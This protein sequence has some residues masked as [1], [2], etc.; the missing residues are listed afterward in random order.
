MT[1]LLLPILLLL[2]HFAF[3]QTKIIFSYSKG[4]SS[5]NNPGVYGNSEQIEFIATSDSNFSLTRYFKVAYSAGKDGK[6][7]TKDTSEL[8]INKYGA[9]NKQY[10]Q[11]WL[12]QLN[13][14][15]ENYTENFVKPRLIKPTK[16]EI[17]IVA[18]SIDKELFF[19]KDFKENRKAIT[20]KIQNFYKL[21]SF[22]IL[23]KPDIE[24]LMVVTD[25]WHRL[26]IQVVN[27]NDTTI[28]QCQFWVPLGQP[29][30]RYDHKDFSNSKTISNLEANTSAQVFLPN[31]SETFKILDMNNIKERYIKWCLEKYFY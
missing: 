18:K 29:I 21:D 19:D 3:G 10:F 27:N 8:P 9:V 14:Q 28:Y 6:T 4:H 24:N 25:N 31:D 15:K 2:G 22:L 12:A 11:N 17:I 1:R 7:F 16:R 5:W 30:S 13:T 20:E 23:T 26:R